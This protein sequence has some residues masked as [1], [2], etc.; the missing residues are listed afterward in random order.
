MHSFLIV[1]ALSVS[2]GAIASAPMVENTWL[3]SIFYWVLIP[4]LLLGFLAVHSQVN[5]F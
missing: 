4:S 1:I 3:R 5:F 2:A